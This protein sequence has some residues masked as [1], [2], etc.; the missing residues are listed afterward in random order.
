[1]EKKPLGSATISATLSLLLEQ[2]HSLKGECP[3]S[4]SSPGELQLTSLGTT[5]LGCDIRPEAGLDVPPAR[6]CSPHKSNCSD[7]ITASR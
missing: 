1:M 3:V 5:D 6:C 4:D 2:D 7:V